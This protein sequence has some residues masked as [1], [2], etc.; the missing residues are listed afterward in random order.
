M[1]SEPEDHPDV[2][3]LDEIALIDNLVRA[4]VVKDLP[5]ELTYPQ[6]EVLGLLARRGDGKTPGEIS[7]ALQVTKSGFTNTLLRLEN[8]G[9]VRVAP[10]SNDGR[11]KQLWLTQAGRDAYRQSM[12]AMRPRIAGLRG[13][14]TQQEFRDA[15]PFL[16]ALRSWLAETP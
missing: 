9:L 12:V 7:R 16:R 15:L 1:A 5:G 2:Q 11:K 14:F 10:A 3:V 8:G 13:G 4:A 6:F